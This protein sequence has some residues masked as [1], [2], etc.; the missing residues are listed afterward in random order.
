MRREMDAGKEEISPASQFLEECRVY[1]LCLK[2][3]DK[4]FEDRY[5]VVEVVWSTLSK[6]SEL[7]GTQE[8]N[9]TFLPLLS[10]G[11]SGEENKKS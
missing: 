4:Y 6:V 7:K 2:G 9:R 8:T 11:A 10:G 1:V 5:T 3:Y